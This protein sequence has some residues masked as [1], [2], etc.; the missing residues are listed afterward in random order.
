M[1]R[2]AG[3]GIVAMLAVLPTGSLECRPNQEQTVRDLV[4]DLGASDPA[5]RA[6]AAC[7]LRAMGSAAA[8]ALPSLTA[9]LSDGAPVEQDICSRSWWRGS[10][11][12]LTSPGEIAAAALVAI[13][14]RAIDPLMSTLKSEAWVARRNAAWALG[15][16]DDHRAV[17]ALIDTLKDSE[18]AVRAQG[19]WALG[20]IDARD[21][22]PVLTGALR[23]PAAR[24]RRQAAWALGAIGDARALQELLT[25]LKDPEPE[26]RRQAAWAIGVLEK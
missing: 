17:S 16:L 13:G 15:A 18:P 8:P 2:G 23:D 12:D 4:L 14:T 26:V 9:A 19:A 21:G 24:V 11:S 20:A 5:V 1:R 10:G 22:V 7:D 25:A 3:I 6:R